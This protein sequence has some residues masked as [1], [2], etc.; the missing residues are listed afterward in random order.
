MQ[1]LVLMEVE[2]YK[3]TRSLL[4]DPLVQARSENIATKL[5]VVLDDGFYS[6]IEIWDTLNEDVLKIISDNSRYIEFDVAL[7][8][9]M[10]NFGYDILSSNTEVRKQALN[11]ILQRIDVIKSLGVTNISLSSPKNSNTLE[12]R[13]QQICLFGEILTTICL[14]AERHNMDVCFESFDV[15]KDKKRLLGMTDEIN[16]FM[17]KIKNDVDNL[18]LTWDLAHFCLENPDYQ[19]SLLS[20]KHFVKR[21]HLSN[22]SLDSAKWYYGDKHIPF[23]EY[24]EIKHSDLL[25]IISMLNLDDNISIAFE[26]ASNLHTTNCDTFNSAYEYNKSLFLHQGL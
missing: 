25:N 26:V 24:G 7:S 15:T 5:K 21:V 19:R 2:L 4:I 23:E 18:F 17:S 16:S 22:Y 12:S 3:L 8:P 14:Y 20:L 6:T 1:L 10:S 9:L 13:H 11:K